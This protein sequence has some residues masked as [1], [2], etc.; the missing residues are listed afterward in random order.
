MVVCQPDAVPA[1]A[2]EPLLSQGENVAVKTRRIDHFEIGQKTRSFGDLTFLGGLELI[3]ANRDLGGLSGLVSLDAGSEILAVTDNGNWVAAN[4]DQGPDGALLGVSDVRIHPL[5]PED[6]NSLRAKW[7]HDTEALA[8]DGD[9]LLVSAERV[10]AIYEYP[11]P[12]RTGAEKMLGQLDVSRGIGALRANKGLEALAAGP[13]GTPLAATVVAIG[14][15]GKTEGHDL[16][17]F[18]FAETGIAEFSIVRSGRYDATDAAFLPD[19]DLLLLERR[20]NVRDFIGMRLR[21]F[22]ADR[23]RPG[24][25]LTGEV[26]LEADFGHQIDNM[27]G[28]AV[29]ETAG[30]DVILTLLSD[31]NRSILQRTLL[32]RFRLEQ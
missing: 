7:G 25:R 28:L 18:L 16:P 11:W 13:E 26:L 12:L 32:L 19:G 27:E 17:G 29:H 15:R 30:G 10:N 24:A 4:I 21:R 22:E 31:N 23:I 8:L 2:A 3:S 9:R 14:E 20:F 5:E 1:R 6:G